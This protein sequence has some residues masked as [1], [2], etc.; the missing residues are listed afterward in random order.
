MTTGHWSWARPPIVKLFKINHFESLE[1]EGARA[2]ARAHRVPRERLGELESAAIARLATGPGGGE[3]PPPAS[4][5]GLRGA[6]V[7]EHVRSDLISQ[8]SLSGAGA[9]AAAKPGQ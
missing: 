3:E 5:H 6:S 1:G 9:R 4:P 7:A 2:R 8:R